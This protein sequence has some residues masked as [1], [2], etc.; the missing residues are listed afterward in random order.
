[1]RQPAAER[2][3]LGGSRHVHPVPRRLSAHEPPP[4]H[5]AELDCGSTAADAG[6]EGRRPVPRGGG[7]TRPVASTAVTGCQPLATMVVTTTPLR[8]SSRRPS[9][10]PRAGTRSRLHAMG[11]T[12]RAGSRVGP[13]RARAAGGRGPHRSMRGVGSRAHRPTRRSMGHATVALGFDLGAPA[14]WPP[15]AGFEEHAMRSTGAVRPRAAL[16]PRKP[17]GRHAQAPSPP[18]WPPR[19]LLAASAPQPP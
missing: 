6:V 9:P 12:A 3:C 13:R 15:G 16:P 7:E 10:A 4:L 18:A 17:R 2:A 5:A 1:M 14:P 8:G 11:G 19:L